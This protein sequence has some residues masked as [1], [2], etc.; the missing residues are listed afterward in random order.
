[1]I[2]TRTLLIVAASG[3]GCA[4][5]AV[6]E[7]FD[8]SPGAEDDSHVAQDT[9]LEAPCPKYGYYVEPLAPCRNEGV[10]CSYGC[11]EALGAFRNRIFTAKCVGGVWNFTSSV[12]C[13]PP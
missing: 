11:G 2:T 12:T 5:T 9:S 7:P 3:I 4:R 10:T 8:S 13:T 1:M 6:D